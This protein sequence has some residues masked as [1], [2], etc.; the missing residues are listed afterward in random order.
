MIRR[1]F[2]LLV[3]VL[4]P[5][6]GV[7]ARG[8][9][10]AA[11]HDHE[12]H[13]EHADGL[14]EIEPVD[15]SDGELLAV[16]A[17]TSILGDVVRAVVGEAANVTVLMERGRN[18]HSYEP[19]PS[20]LRTVERAHLVF[21]NGLGLEENLLDDVESIATGYVVPASAGVEPLEAEHEDEED[22]HHEAGDPH[23]WMDPTNAIV[24]VRNII[25][26]LREADPANAETYEANG[27]AYIHELEEIDAWIREQV[28]SIPAARRKLVVDHKLFGYFA[29]QYD[30]RTIGAVVPATTDTAEPSARDIARLVETI[31][32]EEVRA[33]FVGRTASRS[34]EQ[35]ARTVADEVGRDVVI[36]HTLT[37]SL[38]PAGEPGDTYLGFLRYNV[39]QI[40]TGVS[41]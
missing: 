29:A 11:E 4:M 23:V 5:A 6:S 15:L 1:V 37:G 30:F 8:A 33:I 10:E 36:I 38:A 14:P 26:A 28:A 12:E 27:E 34:L 16:V 9:G 20:A 3:A 21:T 41:R 7:W 13:H 40:M 18:P 24:W 32:D 17:T 25:H 39:R 19:T 2:L 31:R 22:H 35:L